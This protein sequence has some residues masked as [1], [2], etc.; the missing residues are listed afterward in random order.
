MSQ[1]QTNDLVLTM[2]SQSGQFQFS[3][4]MLWLDRDEFG[5]ELFVELRTSSGKLI[6]LT[7]SHLIYVAD[8]PFDLTKQQA[9]T[10]TTFSDAQIIGA[11]STKVIPSTQP[12][13]GDNN[14][15]NYYY[16]YDTE[17]QQQNTQVV[18]GAPDQ[19]AD[20]TNRTN[21]KPL[22]PTNYVPKQSTSTQIFNVDDFAYTIYARNAFVGQ[23]LLINSLDG[24]AGGEEHEIESSNNTKSNDYNQD[25]NQKDLNLNRSPNRLTFNYKGDNNRRNVQSSIKSNSNLQYYQSSTTATIKLDQIVSVNYVTRNGIYAPL[26]REG[27]IVV[28]SVVAS[29]Y[30]V[31][32]DH[33][34]AHLSFAPVRWLNYLHE[35]LFGLRPAIPLE[36]RLLRPE[37][38]NEDGKKSRSDDEL[39]LLARQQNKPRD[40]QSVLNHAT[41]VIYRRNQASIQ[42][43]G[44]KIHWYPMVLFNIARYILPNRYLY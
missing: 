19:S 28:N 42:G 27:N 34:M 44:R 15:N 6:R 31:I 38:V 13:S 1:L 41:P 17:L 26:T 43:S 8:E 37:T 20:N 12:G 10:T 35:W 24:R 29:C 33:D 16:F 9:T 18:S 7:S 36:D 39:L 32:S 30:A 3:P 5:Q 21:N 23:Y 2:N 40:T 11:D 4:I 25:A 14:Q 22:M